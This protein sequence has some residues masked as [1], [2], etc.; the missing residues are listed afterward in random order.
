MKE[1]IFVIGAI[2][3]GT[4]FLSMLLSDDNRKCV[5]DVPMNIILGINLQ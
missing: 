4:I 2:F 1:V 3:G 5:C